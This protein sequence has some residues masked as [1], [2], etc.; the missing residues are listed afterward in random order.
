M[1]LN[2][3]ACLPEWVFLCHCQNM[4]TF[5]REE[6]M[7]SDSSLNVA[8]GAISRGLR[9]HYASLTLF[10]LAVQA[11]CPASLTTPLETCWTPE[12]MHQEIA[13]GYFWVG[14]GSASQPI[15]QTH[16]LVN[17]RFCSGGHRRARAKT[18]MQIMR[19]AADA[20]AMRRA[21]KQQMGHFWVGV[22]SA[23]QP[24]CHTH[25][26]VDRRVCS[27]GHRRARANELK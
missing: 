22:G 14:V 2:T 11:A 17:R 6:G 25:F 8:A 1:T 15:C 19:N 20:G 12:C 13:N 24:T 26:L 18:W 21:P 7:S 23:S 10:I 27:G 9:V 4:Y 16:F 5:S 3:M